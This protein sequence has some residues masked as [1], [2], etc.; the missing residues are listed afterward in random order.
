MCQAL[1]CIATLQGGHQ[2][3]HFTRDEAEAQSGQLNSP[4]SH[5]WPKR[6]PRLD[7]HSLGWPPAQPAPGRGAGHQTE[8][9]HTGFTCCL[10]DL[11]PSLYLRTA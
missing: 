8:V 11:L 4:R 1:L 9:V 6:E 10:P 2:Y 5:G 3:P 7:P